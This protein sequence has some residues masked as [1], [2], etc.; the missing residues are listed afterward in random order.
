[1]ER[2]LKKHTFKAFGLEKLSIFVPPVEGAV[3]LHPDRIKLRKQSETVFFAL[4]L[5]P[6][7]LCL[8]FGGV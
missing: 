6:K 2:N 7:R 4:Y 1:M 5:K 3:G 8:R